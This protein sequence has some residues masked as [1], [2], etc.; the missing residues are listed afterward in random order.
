M[1]Q[2]VTIIVIVTYYIHI[3]IIIPIGIYKCISD[4]FWTI[5]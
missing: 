2:I 3:V 1:L 5:D 4:G